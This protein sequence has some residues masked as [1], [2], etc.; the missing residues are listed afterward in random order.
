MRA[1]L[2]QLGHLL[3]TEPSRQRD[4]ATVPILHDTDPAVHNETSP[5]KS[6]ATQPGR[7]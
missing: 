1:D 6:K 3:F 5:G 4:D 2:Q 7:A